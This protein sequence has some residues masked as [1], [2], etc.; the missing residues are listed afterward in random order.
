[1]GC[2]GRERERLVASIN[3]QPSNGSGLSTARA[4][5]Q[6]SLEFGARGQAWVMVAWPFSFSLSGGIAFMAL[7]TLAD[8]H[9]NYKNTIFTKK[10]V[11]PF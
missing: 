11:R 5:S 2:G 8:R 3:H 10:K 9:G 6:I 1:M 7:R 4:P